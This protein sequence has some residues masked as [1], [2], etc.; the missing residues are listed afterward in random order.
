MADAPLPVDLAQLRDDVV[1]RPAARLV[2]DDQ[3]VG[4]HAPRRS[5]H[6][7]HSPLERGLDAGDHRR[8]VEGRRE[9]GREAVAAAA[10]GLGDAADV[11]LTERAEAHAHRAVDLLLEDAGDLGL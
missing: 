7:A 9:P 5:R 3:S 8:D 2:D 6:D 10:V 11:D 4:L 1:R